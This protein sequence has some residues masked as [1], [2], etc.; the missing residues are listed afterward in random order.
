MKD[1]LGF[2][3]YLPQQNKSGTPERS[4]PAW[5]CSHAELH[6]HL[7]A[8]QYKFLIFCYCPIKSCLAQKTRLS[9]DRKL[10]LPLR[11]GQS[12]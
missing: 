3:D 2:R 9:L 8:C 5:V 11:I 12:K 6:V 1:Q 7:E 10:R 4:L